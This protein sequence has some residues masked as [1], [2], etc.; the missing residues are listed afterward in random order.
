MNI[1]QRVSEI[2]KAVDFIRKDKKVE[3]YM[4][5]THDAVTA[6]T[7]EHFIKHGVII[8]PA[9]VVQ[10]SVKD[11]GTQTSRG[12]PFIRFEA[13]Y[14]FDVVNADDP[15]D[16]FSIEIEA[17]ALD[18]GDK[19][20]GK[21]LSYAKKY[22]VL[23]LL[24]IESGEEEEER[25]EQHKP[26]ESKITPNAGAGDNLTAK[27]KSMIRDT[28]T[29]VTDALNEERDMDAYALCESITEL[30]EKLYLWSLLDSK[31]RRRIKEQA[32]R[33]KASEPK[34]KAV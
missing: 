14:R 5:V 17:H 25:Q 19:A 32:E 29:Q 6:L 30:E 11:T 21:A 23:K 27:Q 34:L 28:Q 1:Y 20:P 31:Q 22:A 8:V 4:A 9:A 13:R 15:A 16:K 18:H 2:R 12:T 10:S 24:E 3:G 26:K 33:E 7:R